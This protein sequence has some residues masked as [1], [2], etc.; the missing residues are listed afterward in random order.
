MSKEKSINR[1]QT[2]IENKKNQILKA[3]EK[4]KTL[5]A[6]LK[7]LETDLQIEQSDTIFNLFAE[8]G[9]TEFDDIMASLNHYLDNNQFPDRKENQSNV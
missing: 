6:Q 8:R 4:V 1:I 5:K 9:I 7:D 3:E 2:N